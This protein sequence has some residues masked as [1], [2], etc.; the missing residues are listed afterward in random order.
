MTIDEENNQVN[1]ML[2]FLKK[3]GLSKK[4]CKLAEKYLDGNCGD[5]LLEQFARIEIRLPQSHWL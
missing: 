4:D 1:E 2:V 5:E 3:L